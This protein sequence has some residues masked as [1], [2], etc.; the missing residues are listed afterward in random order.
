MR[1]QKTYTR[2]DIAKMIIVGTPLTIPN[3]TW[4]RSQIDG[5]I[6]YQNMSTPRLAKKFGLPEKVIANF[7]KTI[8]NR[9]I[10][11]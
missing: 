7:K 9:R 6:K 4:A 2:L 5:L 8:K 11:G 1:G 3:E 10:E